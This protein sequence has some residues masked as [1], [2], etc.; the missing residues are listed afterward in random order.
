MFEE[1]AGFED[2]VP[3][4]SSSFKIGNTYF[5]K[6]PFD[7]LKENCVIAVK[8]RT[9][10]ANTGTQLGVPITLTNNGFEYNTQISFH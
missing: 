2:T 4:C 6:Y 10:S 1:A 3:Y 9:A 7:W 8:A 5:G